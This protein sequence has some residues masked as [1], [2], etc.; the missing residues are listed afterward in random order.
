MCW[1]MS[2]CYRVLVNN[3]RS[4]IMTNDSMALELSLFFKRAINFVILIDEY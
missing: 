4:Y 2:A 1:G 3:F